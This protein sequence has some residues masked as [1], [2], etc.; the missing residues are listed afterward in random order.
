MM[1]NQ[2]KDTEINV[3]KIVNYWIEMSENDFN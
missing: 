3:E 1:L 2:N